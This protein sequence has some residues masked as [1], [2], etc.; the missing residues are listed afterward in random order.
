VIA[1]LTMPTDRP[2][3][4]TICASHRLLNVKPLAFISASEQPFG[5][6]ASISSALIWSPVR[7]RA[8]VYDALI[9]FRADNVAFPT[10]RERRS[11]RGGHCPNRAKCSRARIIAGLSG[12]LTVSGTGREREPKS[13]AFPR[14]I[15]PAVGKV[16]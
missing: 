8:V 12:F 15:G 11:R 3:T 16:L 13:V 10:G 7:P 5:L 2:A 4:S 1:S 9:L 14:L 6:P